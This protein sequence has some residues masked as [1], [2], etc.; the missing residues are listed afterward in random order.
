MT[1]DN[2]QPQASSRK[3]KLPKLELRKFSGKVEDWPEFWDSFCSAIHNDDQLA[4]VDKFKYLRSYLEGPAR[5]AIKGF[6]LTDV[7]YDEAVALLRKR[8]ARPEVIR[9]THINELINLA[10]VYSERNVQRLRAFHDETETHFRAME[11]QG[12]D[13]QTY[14]S[15]VVPMLMSKIPEALRNNMTRFNENHMEWLLDEFLA[16]LEKEL[17]V[18]EGHVPILQMVK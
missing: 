2:G 7:D 3:V 5:N 13:K 9:I 15:V 4:K 16:A 8:F 12:V 11:A 14:S 17:A 18:L 10:P 6:S 1:S